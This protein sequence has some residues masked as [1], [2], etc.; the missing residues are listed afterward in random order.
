[1]TICFI[2]NASAIGGAE[3]VLLETV[4]L[5]KERGVECRVIAGGDG[6]LVQWLRDAG[7]PCAFHRVGSWVSWKRPG[8]WHCAKTIV[9]VVLAV[10]FATKYVRKWN[11]DLVY[12]NSLTVCHGA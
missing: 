1:M 7:V 9:K 4:D 6:E 2:T 12:S 3:R 11:C 5:L 10:L 8:L